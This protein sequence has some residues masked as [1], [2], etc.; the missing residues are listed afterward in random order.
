MHFLINASFYTSHHLHIPGSIFGVKK[1]DK[2]QL[3]S[4][5]ITGFGDLLQELYQTLHFLYTVNVNKIE[6][7][8]PLKGQKREMVFY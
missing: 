5:F 1:P 3:F 6:N 2:T 8:L 7:S 4:K